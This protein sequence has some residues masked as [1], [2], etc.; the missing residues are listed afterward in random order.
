MS[1][2]VVLL[3]PVKPWV[4]AK[5]RLSPQ[6]RTIGGAEPPLLAEAFA[7]DA[8]A[9]ALACPS[10]DEIVIVTD[11]P[12]FSVAGT[13]T[14]PD[15]GGGVLNVALSCAEARVRAARPEV[16]VAAMC[17]DLPCLVADELTIA[18]DE[19]IGGDAERAFVADAEG[20]GTTFLLAHPRV[21]L[22]PLFG[23]GSAQ[24][25][26]RSG[27]APVAAGVPTLRRDVDTAADLEAARDLGVGPHTRAALT[28]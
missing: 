27:A 17:A 10:L 5:S 13:Q 26:A 15:E 25:H 8:I 21:V 22:A 2:P 7:R 19:A 4:R 14:L 3:I 9:A 12:G 11:Q 20:T 6:G 16:A 18:V 24:R 1:T 23:P 28:A